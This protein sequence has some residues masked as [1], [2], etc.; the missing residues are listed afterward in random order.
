MVTERIAFGLK[1]PKP[2]PNTGESINE[3]YNI[4][5]CQT[6]SKS[7]AEFAKLVF[8]NLVSINLKINVP[9]GVRRSN[10]EV[11]II[12]TNAILNALTTPA[13]NR[14][15][16][17]TNK[18]VSAQKARES[19]SNIDTR[20]RM[21]AD[22]IRC[23]FLLTKISSFVTK[24]KKKGTAESNGICNRAKKVPSTPSDII[25]IFQ[26]SRI[27]DIINGIGTPVATEKINIST[28]IIAIKTNVAFNVL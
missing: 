5:F 4:W 11:E 15:A 7:D 3:L 23:L 2:C 28:F 9:S 16:K 8:P 20:R 1:Y 22:I 13:S 26:E 14:I 19:V 6:R 10:T 18:I 24:Y 12:D 17:P 25:C 27:Q 21:N